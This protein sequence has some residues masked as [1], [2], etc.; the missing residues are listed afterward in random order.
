M[1]VEK[2]ENWT[3]AMFG[4]LMHTASTKGIE[5]VRYQHSVVRPQQDVIVW[6]PNGEQQRVANDVTRQFL[7][8]W[9]IE[10]RRVAA[11]DDASRQRAH[12]FR[13]TIIAGGIVLAS[14]IAGSLLDRLINPA[15]TIV[16]HH[17]HV[18]GFPE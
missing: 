8:D 4:A 14:A 15:Q 1:R 18:D 7:A 12:D 11:E 5:I 2:R 6:R 3:D 17:Y 9:E 10:T 16:E 13:V